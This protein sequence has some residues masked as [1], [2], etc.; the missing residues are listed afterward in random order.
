MLDYLLLGIPTDVMFAAVP[1]R[2]KG[3]SSRQRKNDISVPFV[4][5][6]LSS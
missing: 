4:N 6:K 2:E 5:A 3:I 1:L